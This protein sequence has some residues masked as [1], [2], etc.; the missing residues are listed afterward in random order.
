MAMQ[1]RVM[2]VKHPRVVLVTYPKIRVEALRRQTRVVHPRLVPPAH[3]R[4]LL[5]IIPRTE[6]VEPTVI[7]VEL[8]RTLLA[9]LRRQTQVVYLRPVPLAHLRGPLVMTL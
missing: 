1:L 4:E 5:V 3:L 2:A 8:P 7:A 6:A 9:F